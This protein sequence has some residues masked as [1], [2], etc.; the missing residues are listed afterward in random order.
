MRQALFPLAVLLCGVCC[1]VRGEFVGAELPL[2]DQASVDGW[3]GIQ[4]LY[5]HALPANQA[6]NVVRYYADDDLAA[7]I[8][9]DQAYT[10]LPLIVKQEGGSA[11]NGDGTFT[12]WQIGPTH[13]PEEYGEQ[14]FGWGS[15]P[16][17]DDGALYHPGVL[18]WNAGVNNAA[19]GLVSFGDGGPGMHFF[20]VD[21]TEFVP[22]ENIGPVEVGY[23]LSAQSPQIHS[24]VAGGRRYQLNFETG[25]PSSNPGDFNG[26]GTIDLADF[27]ILAD[28]FNSTVPRGENGDSDFS[29][30]VD[31]RDFVNFRADYLAAQAPQLASVPEP[32]AGV[33]GSFA[34]LGA[35]HFVRRRGRRVSA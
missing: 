27:Q 4:V 17:P 12:V 2:E 24:S 20:D 34:V 30:I 32:L 29:G 18:E 1:T 13:I 8:E 21:T 6:V 33:L 35:L 31:L 23:D 28:N 14:E 7:P 22:D 10:L 16:V 25:T 15:F 5:G 11:E 3:S 19:G 26:D 9:N